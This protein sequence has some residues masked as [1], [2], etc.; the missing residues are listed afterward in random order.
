L[1]G[2]EESKGTMGGILEGM[3]KEVR[4]QKIDCVT[5]KMRNGTGGIVG[6]QGGLTRGGF[7]KGEDNE[8]GSTD[9]Q[10]KTKNENQGGKAGEKNEI[11]EAG[12]GFQ[13]Q[14]GTWKDMYYGKGAMGVRG[15]GVEEGQGVK[16]K[17]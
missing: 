17:R 16:N 13:A 3:E 15:M 1:G 7:C 4:V 10:N 5:G 6:R 12:Q 11:S 14:G 9:E 2:G 8:V